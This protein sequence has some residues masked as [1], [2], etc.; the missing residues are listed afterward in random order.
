MAK[1]AILCANSSAL[2]DTGHTTGVSL[3]EIAP[4]VYELERAEHRVDIFSPRGGAVPLDPNSLDFSD[5][6]A[7]DYYERKPFVER[8]AASRK[9]ND[10]DNSYQALLV[11]GGWGCI[12]EFTTELT[13]GEQVAHARIPIMAFVGYGTSLLLQPALMEI[14]KGCKVTA[15]SPKEDN[16]VGF[17]K[18]WPIILSEELHRSGYE[19]AFAKPWSRH[20]IESSRVITA[21]NIFSAQALGETVVRHLSAGVN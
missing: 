12:R 4:I 21:Q 7:R 3:L 8:L 9:L 1:A 17:K 13:I 5:P 19:L 14:F 20:I 11:C 18:F 15:P 16:D 10:L 2:G 6:I